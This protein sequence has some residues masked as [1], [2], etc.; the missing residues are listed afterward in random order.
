MG[1]D[2]SL[3]KEKLGV[4][5]SLRIVGLWVG[6]CTG[7]KIDLKIVSQP[8]LPTSMWPPLINP[9]K[10]F[11]C[12]SEEVVPYVAVDLV[13]LG[14]EVIQDPFMSPSGTGTLDSIS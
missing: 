14:E 13:G 9:C 1:S 11:M 6:H 2:S 10:G 3:F 7:G 5:I 4:L 12:F 8:L